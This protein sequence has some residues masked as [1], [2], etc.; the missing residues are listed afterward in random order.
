MP[1]DSIPVEHHHP[2]TEKFKHMK[3]LISLITIVLIVAIG[4]AS[5]IFF[6]YGAY[7]L[8]ALLTISGFFAVS[9]WIYY[10]IPKREPVFQ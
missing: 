5:F 8:S 7:R 2:F 6:K 9:G 4:I 1:F 3:A 10:L